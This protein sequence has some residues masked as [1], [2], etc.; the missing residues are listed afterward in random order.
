LHIAFFVIRQAQLP[1]GLNSV[2]DKPSSAL[3]LD[4]MKGGFTSSR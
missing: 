2:H 1:C 3:V 4:V